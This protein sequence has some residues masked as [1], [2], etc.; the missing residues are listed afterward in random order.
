MF[1]LAARTVL[2]TCETVEEAVTFLEGVPHAR[3]TNFLL[4]DATGTIAVVEA[5]P[6]GV[7]TTVNDGVGAATNHFRSQAMAVHE[8]DD[9]G[10]SNSEAR[11]AALH[12]WVDATAAPIQLAGLQR[13]LADPD[14]GVCACATERDRSPVETLWSWTATLER[15]AAYLARGRP[16]RT[17][18]E[19]VRL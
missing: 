12:D 16:D 17:P 7:M 9:E 3:N 4:A 18:Y 13:T 14:T 11:L 19:T 10:R 6:D 2:E 15:P 8:P 1:A 5:S